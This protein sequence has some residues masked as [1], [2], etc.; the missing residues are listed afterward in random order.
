MIQSVNGNAVLNNL[1]G[2]FETQTARKIA[3]QKADFD[4]YIQSKAEQSTIPD[5]YSNQSEKATGFEDK[6]ESSKQKRTICSQVE[7]N[8]YCTYLI[9][10]EGNKILINQVPVEQLNQSDT[11][12]SASEN[13]S[14]GQAI[15]KQET[16]LERV[17]KGNVQDMMEILKSCVGI[18]NQIDCKR[19]LKR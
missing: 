10:S 19:Q 1:S 15:N 17:Q 11:L 2:V 13:N 12:A 6:K 16:N 14:L 9:D 3:S 7:G 8:F 5:V 4:S 18:P